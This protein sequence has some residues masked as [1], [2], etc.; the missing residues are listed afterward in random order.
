MA[1]KLQDTGG[2][3]ELL[4]AQRKAHRAAAK[5]AAYEVK[6][7]QQK[8]KRLEVKASKLSNSDL[9]TMFLARQHRCKA[10]QEA[11]A[12]RQRHQRAPDSGED[13]G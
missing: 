5:A 7:A 6:K 8:K 11:S 1:D 9:L 13:D 2:E 12:K 4:V 3:L 10:L